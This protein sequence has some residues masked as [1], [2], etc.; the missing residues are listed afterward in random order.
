MATAGNKTNPQHISRV[1]GCRG[2]KGDAHPRRQA[3]SNYDCMNCRD[4][5]EE[6]KRSAVKMCRGRSYF[7]SLRR[8]QTN[9]K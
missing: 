4:A 7:G 2:D 8:A 3:E 1:I 9:A 6:N 5:K